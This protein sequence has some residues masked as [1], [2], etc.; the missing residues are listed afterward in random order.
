[1]EIFS[2][3]KDNNVIG[4]FIGWHGTETKALR[5]LIPQVRRWHML[6]TQIERH[7]YPYLWQAFMTTPQPVN[8][9]DD[10]QNGG[11]WWEKF[12]TYPRKGRLRIRRMDRHPKGRSFP[13]E[14]S[15]LKGWSVLYGWS[16]PSGTISPKGDD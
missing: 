12:Q 15:V 5:R 16:N 1:M 6:V 2:N 13:E 7:K 8:H 4:L 14:Q 11:S 9:P 10:S 3:N